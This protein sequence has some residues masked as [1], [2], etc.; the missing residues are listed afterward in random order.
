MVEVGM[1]VQ[2]YRNKGSRLWIRY[3]LHLYCSSS[4][5]MTARTSLY[6]T[7]VYCKLMDGVMIVRTRHVQLYT[8]AHSTEMALYNE[9]S[10]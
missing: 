3:M 1:A 9:P 6:T 8:C 10:N 4:N 5:G 7:N 2:K